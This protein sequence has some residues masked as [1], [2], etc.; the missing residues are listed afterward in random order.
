MAAVDALGMI[1]ARTNHAINSGAEAGNATGWVPGLAAVTA[2]TSDMYE[3]SFAFQLVKDAGA[4]VGFVWNGG[5]GYRTDVVTNDVV[6]ARLLVKGTGASIGKRVRI[7]HNSLNAAGTQVNTLIGSDLILTSGWQELTSTDYVVQGVSPVFYAL[8]IRLDGT[9]G[10]AWATGDTLLLDAIDIAVNQPLDPYVYGTYGTIYSFA[11]TAHLSKSL[12]A[13]EE[14]R[15]ITGI[16]GVTTVGSRV[17]LSDAFGNEYDDV[18]DYVTGGEVGSDIDRPYMGSCRLAVT[19]TKLFPAYSWIKVYQDINF[20]SP[21][22]PDIYS[23]IG[24]FRLEQPSGVYLEGTGTVSGVDATIQLDDTTFIARRNV[25]G[26]VVAAVQALLN[27]AGFTGRHAIAASSATLPADG[28]SFERGTSFLL[29]I[30]ELLAMIGYYVLYALTDGTFV[31]GPYV[32][33]NNVEPENVWTIGQD[34]DIVGDI[35]EEPNDDNMYNYVVVRKM[36]NSKV[37]GTRTAENQNPAHPY[38][39]VTLAKLADPS[40]TRIAKVYKTKVVESDK[41]LTTTE[42]AA[43][44]REVLELASMFRYVTVVAMPRRAPNPHSIC[45]LR[46]DGTTAEHL[47]GRYYIESYSTGLVGTDGTMT[48]RAR[49]IENYD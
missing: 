48:I 27:E 7:Q 23:P 12:R 31:S 22:E 25:T 41:L 5:A 34:A 44:A 9:T 4:G 14:P 36:S 32:G 29:A 38:S 47:T 2:I 16:G 37:A 3:G 1:P 42:L 39:T 40:G 43:K 8:M 20:E 45:E 18:T 6:S 15:G 26:N 24:L 10:T 19:D 28:I 11:G 30:N 35:T 46:F 17:F 33:R 21:L 49:R 13:A